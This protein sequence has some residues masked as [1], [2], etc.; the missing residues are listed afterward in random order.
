MNQSSGLGNL[1]ELFQSAKDDGLTKNTMDLVVANLDGP[2]MLTAVGTS[3]DQLA[4]N[5][6]TL[7]M[8]IIDMSGSMAPH[9]SDLIRA[10]NQDYLAAMSGS[11]AADDILVSTVLFNND[12]ELLHGYVT[13]E[14]APPLTRRIYE[15]DNMT[16]LYDAVAAGLTNMVLYAQQLR[17]NG[18]MVRCIVI[19]YSDGADNA[20]RQ[21]ASA[22]RRATEELL[23]QEI[24]SLAYVGFRSG[25]ISDAE[26]H[27]LADA[28]GFPEVLTAGLDHQELRRIFHLVSMS[29][30]S[31]SQQRA[32]SSGFFS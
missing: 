9:A 28:I 21:R 18:V 27:Q 25:G 6:V 19:V 8:N 20:S 4:T 16:A 23:K 1:D 15:P 7:A 24:Y 32:T 17:Q 3:L 31:V 30:I 2:T 5:E 26:L 29:T 12:I 14:N 10:Y 22:V 11:T 13:L